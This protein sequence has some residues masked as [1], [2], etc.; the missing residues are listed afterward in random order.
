MRYK[1]FCDESAFDK[2]TDD[3]AY[4]MGF[5]MADG[6]IYT[7]KGSHTRTIELGLQRQDVQ[8]L[9]KF[10]KF[11]KSNHKIYYGKANG[12]YPRVSI[13]IRSNRLAY[14]LARHGIVQYKKKRITLKLERNKHFWRGMLDGD[15]S[16]QF[17]MIRNFKM[18]IVRLVG[19]LNVIQSFKRYVKTVVPRHHQKIGRFTHS[20]NTY[21]L[22]IVSAM[23]RELLKMLYNH[24]HTSLKRKYE[25]AFMIINQKVNQKR[26][27][28][29]I[30]ANQRNR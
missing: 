17:A 19:T 16:L 25:M 3:S 29:L 6:C 23:A 21:Y 30:A 28:M 1:Y 14:A 24:S 4:W 27:R 26:S 22:N 10:R 5:L 8:Q 13:Q 15:G 18:P 20:K 9:L 12:K 7:H 11:L 2:V